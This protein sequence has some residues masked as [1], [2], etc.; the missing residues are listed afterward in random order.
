MQFQFHN[1]NLVLYEDAWAQQ[2]K[3]FEQKNLL[4]RVELGF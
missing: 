3:P 1:A 4:E 2:T